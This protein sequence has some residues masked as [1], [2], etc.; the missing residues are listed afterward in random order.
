M[1]ATTTTTT[2]MTLIAGENAWI[3]EKGHVKQHCESE[4]RLEVRPRRD[5]VRRYL[6]LDCLVEDAQPLADL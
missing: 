3:G 5:E 4:H 2:T 1:T 6:F